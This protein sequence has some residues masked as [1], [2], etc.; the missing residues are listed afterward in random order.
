[1]SAALT[2]YFQLGAALKARLRDPAH[3]L[4]L[5]DVGDLAPL[6]DALSG[7][8]D[9]EIAQRL[10][11][12]AP[13]SPAAFIGYDTDLTQFDTDGGGHLLFQ[14]WLV[15]L[16][17]KSA[18]GAASG[19]GVME[20]AGPILFETLQCLSGWRPDIVGV[21]ELQHVAGPR[22]AF[23]AGVGLFPLAFLVPFYVPGANL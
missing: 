8:K 7:A 15:V 19:S 20:A 14:R 4:G 6:A 22:P 18:A 13:R 21:G 5:V 16:V 17:I 12:L 2:D 9:S 10:S 3:A 11:A 23:G 1:M